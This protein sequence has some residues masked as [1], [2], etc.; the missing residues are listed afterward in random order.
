MWVQG[1]KAQPCP[2]GV[3]WE[4]EAGNT[5][6]SGPW[7]K[8]RHFL[9]KYLETAFYTCPHP[10]FRPAFAHTHMENKL[11]ASIHHTNS[12]HFRNFVSK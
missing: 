12:P 2:Q 6:L 7:T 8:K 1:S 10:L 9:A 5:S 4:D 3:D 11:T